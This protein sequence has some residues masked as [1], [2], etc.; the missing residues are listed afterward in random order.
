MALFLFII[1]ARDD[2]T[3]VIF[4]LKFYFK[5]LKNIENILKIL[6]SSSVLL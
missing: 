6:F 2:G 3:L 1:E 4:E 5:S